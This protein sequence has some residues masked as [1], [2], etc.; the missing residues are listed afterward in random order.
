M[1]VKNEPMSTASKKPATSDL[2]QSEPSSYRHTIG[3]VSAFAA[4]VGITVAIFLMRDQISGLAVYG[5]AGVLLTTTLSNATVFV[6]AP[7]AAVLFA[8]DGG[9]HPILVGLSAGIGA[10]IGEMVG[11]LAGVGGRAVMQDRPIYQRIHNWMVKYGIAVIFLLA[12]IPN[13]VFDVGGVLAGAMRVP[14][15]K[16]AAATALGKSLRFIIIATSA[17]WFVT[18]NGGL[19]F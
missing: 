14:A 17:A 2:K 16:F 15:R 13:P 5:Y 3:Q 19:G 11:Y 1:A 12:L 7:T 9:L 10:T 6:P 18:Q 8:V 4:S